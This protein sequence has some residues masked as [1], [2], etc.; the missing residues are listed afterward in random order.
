MLQNAPTLD[1]RSVD[2]EENGPRQVCVGAELGAGLGVDD[3][4]GVGAGDLALLDVAHPLL[5]PRQ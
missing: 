2:T 1:I 5:Y 4:A 3:G